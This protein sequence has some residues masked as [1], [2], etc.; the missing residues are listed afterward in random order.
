MI[1]LASRSPRRRELLDQLG[2]RFEVLDL[3]IDESPL[4]G[5]TPQALVRRLAAAKAEAGKRLLDAGDAH[6]VLGADTIVMLDAQVLGKPRDA[7]HA[8]ELLMRLSGRCH[9]VLSAVALASNKG[10]ETRTSESRV[11]FRR[12]SRRECQSYAEGGEPLD[13][14]GGYAIQGQAA[15]FVSEL[16]GSYSGVVGLPLYET[17]ELLAAAG[18][19]LFPGD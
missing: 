12:L 14:A 5:E 2:V 16:H 9:H 18:I 1:Y 3:E 11:C 4:V 13:K 17:A 15:A 19:A 8:C 10:S 6:L 7:T